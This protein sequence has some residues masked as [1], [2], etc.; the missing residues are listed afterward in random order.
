MFFNFSTFRIGVLSGAICLGLIAGSG[1]ADPALGTAI[2]DA[3]LA[4]LNTTIYPDG[5]GLPV[6]SESV[7]AG[8]AIYREQCVICHGDD[9]RG[10]MGVG[11]PGVAGKPLYGS[12]WTT[13]S[14]WPYASSIFD[15]IR[16]GMP[17]YNPKELSDEEVYAVT[18]YIL[19]MNGLLDE[20]ASVDQD[21][22]PQVYMPSRDYF[23]SKWEREEKDM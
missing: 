6:G 2:T 21:S 15:F 17:P 18:A 3:E 20:E 12:D 23:Y 13:G 16:R 11:V 19:H 1:R 14:A 8:A 4:H 7:Q 5:A 9:G 10:D 22:L